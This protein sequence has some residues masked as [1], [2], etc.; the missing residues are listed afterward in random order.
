MSAREPGVFA[1]RPLAEKDFEAWLPLWQG[2]LTFYKA[3]LGDAQ[4]RLTWKRIHD[5]A[6]PMHALGAFLGDAMVGF[7]V[8]LFHLSSW[9]A[10]SYCYLEDL[11]TAEAARGKGAAGA[12]I[13]A[14]AEAARAKGASKLY[15]QTHVTNTQAQALYDRVAENEGFIVYSRGL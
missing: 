8:Y 5:P 9:G 15:W 7:T 1:I 3:S 13:E 2:Y 4:T 12:L 11:F 10:T 6:E 14:V